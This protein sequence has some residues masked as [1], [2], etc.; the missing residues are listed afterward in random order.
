[1]IWF[2]FVSMKSRLGVVYGLPVIRAYQKHRR[3]GADSRPE[4][5]RLSFILYLERPN[6][7]I[8][9]AQVLNVKVDQQ[10]PSV[11]TRF[12]VKYVVD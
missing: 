3:V 11:T 5:M 4:P 8:S 10:A 9:P 2:E 1:M 6:E 12:I 7:R